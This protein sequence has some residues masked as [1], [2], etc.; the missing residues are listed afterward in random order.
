VN[1]LASPRITE[2]L[3]SSLHARIARFTAGVSPAALAL[4]YLDWAMHLL[5]APRKHAELVKKAAR[6]AMRLFAHACRCASGNEQPP[7]CIEPLPQDRR[8]TGDRWQQFPYLMH[9]AFLL[10]QQWLA[11]R[12]HR[13]PGRLPPS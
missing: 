9:Q 6:N 4:A 7:P 2:T 13:R 11:C 12:H 1:L 3:D 10:N 5:A 8:F